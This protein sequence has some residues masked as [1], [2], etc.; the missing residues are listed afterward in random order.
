MRNA[1]ANARQHANGAELRLSFDD[2]VNGAVLNIEDF[3]PDGR[4]GHMPMD[5]GAGL[6]M[7]ILRRAC[8]ALGWECHIEAVSTGVRLQ[9]E[10]SKR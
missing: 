8:T 5:D 7:I 2:S 4:L 10:L 1:F 3:D 6:G 9:I